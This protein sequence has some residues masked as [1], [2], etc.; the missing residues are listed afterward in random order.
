[1][2]EYYDYTQPVIGPRPR[3]AVESNAARS[4]SAAGQHPHMVRDDR[5]HNPQQMYEGQGGRPL[6]GA[7]QA[8]QQPRPQQAPPSDDGFLGKL[9]LVGAVGFIAYMVGK[10]SGEEETEID[11]AEVMEARRNPAPLPQQQPTVVVVPPAGISVT[12]QQPPAPAAAAQPPLLP[13]P[14]VIPQASHP[15]IDIPQPI[16]SGGVDVAGVPV[17]QTPETVEVQDAV[18]VEDDKPKRTRRT[19]QARDEDGHY[20]PAGTR[21]RAGVEGED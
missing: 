5:H 16:A 7:H 19:T 14:I 11:M 8:Q 10:G 2:S 18:V 1:M 15:V 17:V 12:A 21:K 4:P 6:A 20:M 3:H 9:L 13:Q